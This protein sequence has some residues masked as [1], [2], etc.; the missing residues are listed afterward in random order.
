MSEDQTK[1]K[2]KKLTTIDIHHRRVHPGSQ[3][4]DPSARAAKF[5]Y[6]QQPLAHDNTVRVCLCVQILHVASS[7]APF[8]SK[9]TVISD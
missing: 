2:V 5:T 8:F 1:T 7:P 9:D 3:Q 6:S 4:Q